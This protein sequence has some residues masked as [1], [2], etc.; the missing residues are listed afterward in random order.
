MSG[1]EQ[2]EH[3]ED[4]QTIES[5]SRWPEQRAYELL[6]PIVVHGDPPPVRARQTGAPERT[7]H[8]TRAFRCRSTSGCLNQKRS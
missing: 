7:L 8:P 3:T 4:W 5:L 1:R 6:R 2:V